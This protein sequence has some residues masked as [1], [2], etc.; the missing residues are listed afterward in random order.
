VQIHAKLR[1]SSLGFG[2]ATGGLDGMP[3][4]DKS[5]TFIQI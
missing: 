4:N 5:V 2:P 1:R 3:L